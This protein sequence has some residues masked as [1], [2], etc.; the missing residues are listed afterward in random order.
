[1]VF[2]S[3]CDA[4]YNCHPDAKGQS[5][6][7]IY[8][9]GERG[10][11]LARSAKQK[12]VARS[13]TNAEIIA[14][15]DNGPEVIWTRR[16]FADIGYPQESPTEVE[17]D[18]ESTIYMVENKVFDT[19]RS[20]HINVRYFWSSQLVDDGEIVLVP[21]DTTEIFSNVLTK[22]IVG[23]VFDRDVRRLRGLK[24]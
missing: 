13:S 12:L 1:M 17:Q 8:F 10:L 5:G 22:P 9:A 21:T 20:K 24:G 14:L 15:H 16:F 6:T 19:R 2:Q 11:I 3:S 4:S 23:A 7:L 18:N